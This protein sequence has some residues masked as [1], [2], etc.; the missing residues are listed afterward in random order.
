MEKKEAQARLDAIKLEVK[1]LESLI[2]KPEEPEY[3]DGTVGY[4]WDSI[5]GEYCKCLGELEEIESEGNYRY[6]A[7]TP[8]D[9]QC[10]SHF[11][12][13]KEAILPPPIKWEGGSRPV[14]CNTIV[15]VT[16]RSGSTRVAR[17]D[18]LD[19]RNIDNSGSDIV[20]Y[21]VIR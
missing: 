21:Q 10:Y 3:P 16:M 18:R 1:A 8:D 14:T 6:H 19:W 4:F 17:G 15:L 12:P 5:D 11:E 20:S 9:G 13:I 7:M 2:N